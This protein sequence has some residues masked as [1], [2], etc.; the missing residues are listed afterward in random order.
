MVE[1]GAPA[2]QP[3]ESVMHRVKRRG[4]ARIVRQAKEPVGTAQRRRTAESD[5]EAVIVPMYV[6]DGGLNLRHR[7]VHIGHRQVASQ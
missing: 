7:I 1:H 6:V 4:D 5:L 2:V 3:H